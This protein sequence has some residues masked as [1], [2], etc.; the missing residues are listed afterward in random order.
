MGGST[1]RSAGYDVNISSRSLLA[2][3]NRLPTCSI[4]GGRN[5]VHLFSESRLGRYCSSGRRRSRPSGRDFGNS[6]D[7]PGSSA[8]PCNTS[9]KTCRAQSGRGRWRWLGRFRA[10][11]IPQPAPRLRETRAATGLH[12]RQIPTGKRDDGVDIAKV[13]KLDCVMVNRLGWQSQSP[14]APNLCSLQRTRK[15]K[16]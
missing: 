4:S 13:L 9:R 15:A 11:M 12:A 14:H 2:S 7:T 5:R 16:R 8:R 6:R 10:A 1:Q 3:M